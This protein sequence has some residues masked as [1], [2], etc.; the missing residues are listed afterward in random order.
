[1]F[2]DVCFR[3]TVFMNGSLLIHSV[4]SS[5]EGFYSCVGIPGDSNQVPQTYT[6]ELSIAC[7]LC[8]IFWVCSKSVRQPAE[9]FC[10]TCQ[11]ISGKHI[12]YLLAYSHSVFGCCLHQPATL[13]WYILYH[14]FFDL[15][16]YAV[17]V[18]NFV[19]IFSSEVV[20]CDRVSVCNTLWITLCC[21]ERLAV[22]CALVFF[23][24]MKWFSRNEVY[25]CEI[26]CSDS[27]D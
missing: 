25:G 14:I 7:E 27:N 24:K 26:L 18:V 3:M 19:D 9:L 15:I 16:S 23:Q 12:R 1:M 4:K 20:V 22:L 8:L 10:C 11:R 13:L 5:D 17:C 2:L 21:V 6:A